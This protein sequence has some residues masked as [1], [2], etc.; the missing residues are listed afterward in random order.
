MENIILTFFIANAIF[1]GLFS[2]RAHCMVF[3]YIKKS[4]NI[5]MKCPEHYI[6]IIMGILFYLGSI[7]I[8]Q[9]DLPEFKKLMPNLIK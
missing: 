1:W 9:R 3:D 7:Y 2:H 8:A 5:K 6:H 4:F